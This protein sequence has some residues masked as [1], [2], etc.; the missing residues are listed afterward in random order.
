M[1][2]VSSGLEIL[3]LAQSIFWITVVLPAGGAS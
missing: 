1:I 3:G 2:W